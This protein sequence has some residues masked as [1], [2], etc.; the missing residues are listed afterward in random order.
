HSVTGGVFRHDYILRY[1]HPMGSYE[2]LRL[3]KVIFRIGWEDLNNQW[4][5]N[6]M[7]R[8]QRGLVIKQ[9]LMTYELSHSLVV[10]TSTDSHARLL[11]RTSLWIFK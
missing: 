4:V 10:E 7:I 3:N 5:P 1:H 9:K 11:L 6:D 8:L 2:A